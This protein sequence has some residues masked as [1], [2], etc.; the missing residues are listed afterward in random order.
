M[1][2]LEKFLTSSVRGPKRGVYEQLLLTKLLSANR[3]DPLKRIRLIGETAWFIDKEK[4]DGLGIDLTL[5]ER[6][7]KVAVSLENTSLQLRHTDGI[8]NPSQTYPITW[9]F[10]ITEENY[11]KYIA[12]WYSNQLLDHYIDYVIPLN[13]RSERV[14]ESQSYGMQFFSLSNSLTKVG[15]STLVNSFVAWASPIITEIEAKIASTI[16]PQAWSDV[17][18]REELA[19][20]GTVQ[21]GDK[22]D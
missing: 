2:D 7:F 22:V 18:R 12:S 9:N 16:S 21:V 8:L 6:I 10:E 15:Y 1:S 17:F 20:G 19:K 13:R 4:A 14:I 3:G 11:K 5:I